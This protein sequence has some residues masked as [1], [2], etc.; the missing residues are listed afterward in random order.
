MLDHKLNPTY[1]S[2]VGH[3]RERYFPQFRRL[4]SPKSRPKQVSA[5]WWPATWFVDGHC[6]VASHGE[7]RERGN[8]FSHVSSYKGTH[9]IMH[10]DVQRQ[11]LHLI[12]I[13]GHLLSLRSL[14]LTTMQCQGTS[15]AFLIGWLTCWQ[16]GALCLAHHR[17]VDSWQ[18]LAQG[19]RAAAALCLCGSLCSSR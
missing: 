4:R 3:W 5:L 14:P 16:V 12:H 1:I 11:H 15:R 10:I 9:L 13:W 17:D 19:M 2:L 6:L 18:H 7:N 8:T